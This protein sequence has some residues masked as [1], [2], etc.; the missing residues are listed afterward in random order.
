[1]KNIHLDKIAINVHARRI[2]LTILEENPM[3]ERILRSAASADEAMELIKEWITRI[4]RVMTN[5]NIRPKRGNRDVSIR[6]SIKEYVLSISLMTAE[7]HFFS[8]SVMNF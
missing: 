4:N 2:L 5:L 1:M 8:L 7:C 6:Y 3:L